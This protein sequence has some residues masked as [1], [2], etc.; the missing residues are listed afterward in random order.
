MEFVKEEIDSGHDKHHKHLQDRLN[1]KKAKRLP[2]EQ[3]M[4]QEPNEQKW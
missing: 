1:R 4:V 2:K 3:E